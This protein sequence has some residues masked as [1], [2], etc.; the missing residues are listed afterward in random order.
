MLNKLLWLT[1]LVTITACTVYVTNGGLDGGQPTVTPTPQII[2]TATPEK[3]TNTATPGKTATPVPPTAT[4]KPPTA[5]KTTLPPTATATVKPPTATPTA[6]FTATATYTP[7]V[8]AMTYVVQPATPVFMTNFAHLDAG[9]N[10]QGVAGQVFD[11]TGTPVKNDVVKITGTYNN[12][13]VSLLGVTGMVSGNPYGPGSYEIVLGK[14][15]IN[16]IDLLSIQVFD[17]AGKALTDPLKFS[18][19]SDCTKNLV[20]INFKAK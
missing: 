17:A 10:W 3:G 6:T 18:T 12:A 16:S 1:I 13:A 7:T 9:C 8:P 15:A 5:T 11:S 14:T 19:S 2:V 20:V 4:I